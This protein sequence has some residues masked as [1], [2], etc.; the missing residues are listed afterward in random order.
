MIRNEFGASAGGPLYLGSVYDGR[1]KTFWFAAYEGRRQ[2]ESSFAQDIVPT[3]AM[4]AGDFSGLIDADGNQVHIYDPLTT[5]ANGVRRQFPNDRIP[6]NRLSPFYKAV[7]AIT[8]L[9]TNDTLPTQGPNFEKFYASPTDANTFTIK[10]DHKFS[11]KDSLS[12]RFTRSRQLSKTFG[13]VYG[14]PAPGVEG[15]GS[16]RGDAKVYDPSIQH[17]HVFS[18]TFLNEL[19]VAAH[20]SNKGS[21]TLGDLTDWA[22]KLGLPNPFGVTGWPTFYASEVTYNYF[23]FDGDNRKDEALTA[24]IAEDNLTWVKGKHSM[25]FGGKFRQEYNN[26]RE[27]QQAQGSHDFG[28]DWTALYDPAND[29]AVQFTGSGLADM[30][31]GLPTTL[32]NQ[33]NRGFYYFRQKEFGLYFHDNWKVT[34]R[35]TLDLGVRWDKWTPYSEK[36]NRLVN[37]DLD[38]FANTFQVITPKNVRMEDLPGI[39]PSVLSSWAARGLTWKT[40]QEAGYPADLFAADNNNFGPRVGAAFKITDKT[41]L[42]GGYGE[43]FWPM[44]LAQILQASRTNAPLNLLY[45]SRFSRFD[46]TATYGLQH[47]PGPDFFIPQ[48]KVDIGA[49]GLISPD[50]QSFRVFDGRNWKDARAQSWHLSLEREVMRNTALRLSYIGDHG[51]D[52]EQVFAVNSRVEYNYVLNT[53]LAPPGLRDLM[54]VNPNWNFGGSKNRTGYSNTHSAQVEIERKYSNGLAFQW[55]YTFTRS[56]TTTDAGGFTNGG[57]GGVNDINGQATVPEKLQL[58]G[59]PDL[60]YDQRLALVYYNSTVIPAHRIRYNGIYDFPFGRGKHFGSSI[61]RGLDLL[62]GGWQVAFIGDWRGGFWKSVANNRYLQGDPTLSPDQRPI[63][64][65]FG[66]PQRLW[67]RGDFSISDSDA[68]MNPAGAVDAVRGLV[69]VDRSQ[70]VLH[71]LGPGF[72]NRIPL[73]L[74]DGSTRLTTILDTVNPNARA[75]YQGP[76]A[77][78]DDISVYKNFKI[79]EKVNAR[80][81]AD[82]FNAFNHP[83]DVD[84]NTTTGLQDL[85]IQRNDPRIIQFSLR[86]DW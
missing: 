73:P 5:D 21:G 86:L 30:A 42:R 33:Y 26:V 76:G 19:L 57:G 52:L 7:Q 46:G 79:T 22:G 1:N 60:S 53:G 12:A 50:A 11:D 45:S 77:W 29:A 49:G 84:P 10:G 38:T 75:F 43:Y 6:E 3:P 69:P 8:A 25:K 39:P 62:V 61:S 72:D 13:G 24:Y 56:R 40:A 59:Q 17:T 34:P 32:R 54:R 36:Q 68:A 15:P 82:F 70:R 67:F 83:N 63:I 55:F 35:L 47:A 28:P 23:A 2:R 27:L 80:F 9:P 4:W 65:I 44:P 37:L 51:R 14:N 64:N 41:V 81:S 18:P 31:L 78:N 66:A 74:A 58:L 20:R 48:A 71:P 85:S 16:L